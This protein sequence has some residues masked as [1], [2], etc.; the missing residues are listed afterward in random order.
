METIKAWFEAFKN[1]LG[2]QITTKS[3]YFFKGWGEKKKELKWK[4]LQSE[5][6]GITSQS[7]QNDCSVMTELLYVPGTKMS[8]GR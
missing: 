4:G 1:I 6:H 5:L 7:L 3:K 2:L 8:K